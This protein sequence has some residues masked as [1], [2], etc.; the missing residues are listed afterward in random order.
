MLA[1]PRQVLSIVQAIQTNDGPVCRLS[2]IHNPRAEIIGIKIQVG[3]RT[4]CMLFPFTED[5]FLYLLQELE[6]QS[7]RQGNPQIQLTPFEI[8]KASV[9]ANVQRIKGAA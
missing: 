7:N 9:L 8:Y 2:W 5:V 6:W 4:E 3:T 1:T